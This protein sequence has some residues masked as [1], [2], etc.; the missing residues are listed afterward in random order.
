MF[1]TPNAGM[2]GSQ[3]WSGLMLLIGATRERSGSWHFPV[4]VARIIGAID[5]ILLI[6]AM[7]LLRAQPFRPWWLV[8]LA[9]CVALLLVLWFVFTRH[10]CRL[11]L[12]SETVEAYCW[13]FVPFR[14]QYLSSLSP[15]LHY[16]LI[17]VTNG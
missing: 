11:M 6:L 16:Q 14:H 4:Y 13:K 17:H 7:A 5:V 2:K 3:F 10:L 1:S 9:A 8:S 15:S 12:G